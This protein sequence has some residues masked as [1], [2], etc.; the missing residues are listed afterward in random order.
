MPRLSQLLE[1]RF[2]EAIKYPEAGYAWRIAHSNDA[3]LMHLS[4]KDLVFASR[5][6]VLRAIESLEAAGISSIA[7]IY[8]MDDA[9]FLQIACRDL[10]W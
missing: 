2:C 5:Q 1:P 6:D 3:L 8:K 10:A 7:E 9:A 4:G